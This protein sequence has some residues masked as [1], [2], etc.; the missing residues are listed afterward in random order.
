MPRVTLRSR[1][2]PMPKVTLMPGMTARC[3]RA[4]G[5]AVAV[6]VPA[7]PSTL[8]ALIAPV[9]HA[10]SD[11]Y[12]SRPIKLVVAYAPGGPVDSTARILAP[13]L[14]QRLNAPIIVENRPGAGGTIGSDSVAKAVPDGYTLLFAA[15][16]PHT[17]SPHI[18]KKMPFD[19][20]KD[21]API[22]LVVD[23]ANVL[24][25]NNDLPF[26]SVADLVAFAKANPQK[27]TFGSAGN[28]ASNHLSGELLRRLTGTEMVHVPYRG[29][30]PAM[31]DVIGGKITMMFDITGTATAYIAGGKVRPL[32]VT[33]VNRNRS[34]PNVPTM[35]EAGVPG[36]DVI[37][38]FGV[39][40]PPGLPR[41]IVDRINQALRAILADAVLT[42]RLQGLGYERRVSSPEEFET[43]IR[44]DLELWGRVVRDAH[45]EPE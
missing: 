12:P 9:A 26:R 33:S 6:L 37:G 45:I 44:K 31:T 21:F 43:Q 15:S 41:P 2:T 28:G 19:P 13:L 3:V 40:G 11:A 5:F 39:M 38:W 42:E 1:V 29:N 34:L 18:Q 10:Q 16:P 23:Y 4:I 17:I 24:V 8:I 30:A 20:I 7:V 25:I 27:V 36:F 14:G 35:I 22:S 32:A